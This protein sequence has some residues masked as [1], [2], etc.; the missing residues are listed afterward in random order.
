LPVTVAIINYPFDPQVTTAQVK[1]ALAATGLRATAVTPAIYSRQFQKG[2][3]TNPDPAVRAEAVALCQEAV[4][5]A[6][7]LGPPG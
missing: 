5:G 6:K 7:E 3:F 4:G 1:R 2:A